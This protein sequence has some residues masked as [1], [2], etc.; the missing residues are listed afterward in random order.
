MQTSHMELD[1]ARRTLRTDWERRTG[2]YRLSATDGYTDGFWDG[3]LWAAAR[4]L[5]AFSELDRDRV[6]ELLG[7]YPREAEGQGF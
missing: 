5:A 3:R 6:V 2:S 4:L 7:I 1:E